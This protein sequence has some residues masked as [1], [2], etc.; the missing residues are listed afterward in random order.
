MMGFVPAVDIDKMLEQSV[1]IWFDGVRGDRVL[2]KVGPEVARFFKQK[3]YFPLQK[4]V[5]EHKD[6]SIVLET[7]PAHP[8][9]ITHTIMHWMP[10]LTV[11]EPESFKEEI[12]KTV[13]AYLKSL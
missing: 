10:Y 3:I 13:T 2:I 6:G 8:E 9:E 4:I 5:T 12:K 7:Y 1:N 11:M